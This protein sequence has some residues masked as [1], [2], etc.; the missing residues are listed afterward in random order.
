VVAV[1]GFYNNFGRYVDFVGGDLVRVGELLDGEG[2]LLS[3][4]CGFIAELLE[5]YEGLGYREDKGGW[6]RVVGYVST[7]RVWGVGSPIWGISARRALWSLFSACIAVVVVGGG[8]RA[9]VGMRINQWTR[10]VL[11]G[12]YVGASGS[13]K[14][15]NFVSVRKSASGL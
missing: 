8:W 6:S 12:V 5:V 10:G 1:N 3:G 15:V 7:M 2:L 4:T 9:S 11:V 14:C 13:P